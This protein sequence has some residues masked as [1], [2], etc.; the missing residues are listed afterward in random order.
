MSDWAGFWLACA[1]V[2]SAN[3]FTTSDLA[4]ISIA[5]IEAGGEM[6]GEW[7]ENDTC[8]KDKDE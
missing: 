5:C 8:V 6:R 7:Y 3:S 1:I 4:L 2:L